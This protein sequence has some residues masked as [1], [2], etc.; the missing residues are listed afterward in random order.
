MQP[1]C[2]FRSIHGKWLKSISMDHNAANGVRRWT[3]SR[4]RMKSNAVL[5][6]VNYVGMVLCGQNNFQVCVCVCVWENGPVFLST[7]QWVAGESK[8]LF[9]CHRP[10]L[11]YG[12]VTMEPRIMPPLPPPSHAPFILVNFRLGWAEEIFFVFFPCRISTAFPDR[13]RGRKKS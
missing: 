5:C 4:L 11:V 7:S 10:D 9:T 12:G 6:H 13:H 3:Q 2:L 1:V 8:P